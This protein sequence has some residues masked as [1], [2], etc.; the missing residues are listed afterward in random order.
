MAVPIQP[1]VLIVTVSRT[2]IG[3]CVQY[4]HRLGKGVSCS[5]P[6]RSCISLF[7]MR[8]SVYYVV[9]DGMAPTNCAVRAEFRVI[10]QTCPC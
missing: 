3:N 1:G 7:Q 6:I 10:T 2:D 9:Q 5:G 4:S 8:V